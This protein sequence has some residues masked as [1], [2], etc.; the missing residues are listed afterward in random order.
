MA[1]EWIDSDGKACYDSIV[2][3]FILSQSDVMVV[4][5]FYFVKI[6]VSGMT[7]GKLTL[8]SLSGYP[9]ITED[10]EYEYLLQAVFD[11]FIINPGTISGGVFNGCVDDIE[12]NLIPT[13]IIKSIDGDV[14]FTM[15]STTG[16]TADRDYIQY[17]L[18]WTEIEEGCYYIE[19]SDG[20]LTYSSYCFHVKLIHTCS[21]QLEWTNDQDAFG[22]NY[23]GLSFTQS[24]RVDGKLWKPRFPTEDKEVYTF[25]DG[26]KKITYARVYEEKDLTIKEAPDYIHRAIAIGINSDE[27]YIDNIESVFEDQEYTPTWRNS[28]N[29]APSNVVVK[30]SVQDL[31]NSNC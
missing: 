6:T 17:Q 13:Y 9:E 27:F 29:L 15:D 30:Q 26:S 12:V 8:Q 4:G 22:F 16:I 25:S 28:S 5:Q 18:N 31:L 24:L 1:N 7:Q 11:D 20:V 14:I 2:E 3:G 10:G 23:S 19:F 21:L